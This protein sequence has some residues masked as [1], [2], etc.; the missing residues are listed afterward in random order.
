MWD[1]LCWNRRGDLSI[2]WLVGR[3]VFGGQE[4]PDKQ[5]RAALRADARVFRE[6]DR[7]PKGTK[8]SGCSSNRPVV[9]R[10]VLHTA[11]RTG[12]HG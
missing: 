3:Q 4:A 5:G 1:Y 11:S 2:S 8:K 10:Y 7:A 6:Q 9:V 12:A